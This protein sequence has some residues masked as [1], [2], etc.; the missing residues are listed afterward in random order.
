MKEEGFV[1]WV[2]GRWFS[3]GSE[4]DPCFKM[5][6]KLKLL[7]EDLKVWNREVFGRVDIRIFKA[8][9]EIREL[10][11]KAGSG[12]L[13]SEEDASRVERRQE[14]ER[15]L[16][17]EEISWRQKS[18]V[19]WLKEGDKNT[20]FFHKVANAHY[21]A[22]Q[23]RRV[24]YEDKED[25][26]VG[27]VDFYQSLYS[28]CGDWSPKLD[29]VS[30]NSLGQ[31]DRMGM[32]LQFS[33]EEVVA[34]LSSMKGDKA[35]GPDGFTMAFF[36]KCWEVVKSDIM[37]VFDFFHTTLR[38]E[39]SF[40]ATFLDLIP[41]KVGAIE[42]EDFRPISLIGSIYKLI[43]KVLSLR[44]RKVVGKLV[45]E[46]QHTFV[47]DLQILDA[48]FIANEA[49]DS[50]LKDEVPGLLCKLDIEKA[51]DHVR[52]DFFDVYA[53]EDGL[54]GEME[55]VDLFLYILGA[56]FSFD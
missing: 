41:K 37:E 40:N 5:A 12:V 34:A 56:F 39:K 2:K 26:K 6:K 16:L 15:L 4:G 35:P 9:E 33:E 42:L 49:V 38:F 13:S 23:I 44:L 18:R 43:A 30:F 29:G 20:M 17:L 54:W 14:L 52:W 10:D 51:Y 45:S 27:I 7:K 46:S 47:G 8:L 21:S 50:R 11:E 1:E 36:Q 24:L 53:R 3:Y 22:N 28:D 55:K 31:E 19:Q 32:E 48:S 25:I